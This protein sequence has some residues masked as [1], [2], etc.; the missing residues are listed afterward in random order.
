MHRVSE[1]VFQNLDIELKYSFASLVPRP[2]ITAFFAI[3]EEDVACFFLQWLQK[4]YEG[5]PGYEATHLL[6]I[7]K[8]SYYI[9]LSESLKLVICVAWGCLMCHPSFEKVH[10]NCLY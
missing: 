9:V 10:V 6:N 4:S 8:R 7:Q 1:I 5:R 3:V 2:P